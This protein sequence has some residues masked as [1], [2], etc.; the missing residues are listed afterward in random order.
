MNFIDLE[1]DKIGITCDDDLKFFVEESKCHKLYFD[2]NAAS[3]Q[4]LSRKRSRSQMTEEVEGSRKIRKLLKE[5]DL[6]SD[7]SAMDTDDESD[8]SPGASTSDSSKTSS[9]TDNAQEPVDE[10]QPSTSA[11]ASNQQTPKVNIISVDII[12]PS[13][14]QIND[15]A[16]IHISDDNGNAGQSAD[17][18]AKD[19]NDVPIFEIDENSQENNDNENDVQIVPDETQEKTSVAEENIQQS[20]QKQPTKK[21][22]ETNRII[23]SD[24]SDDE[25]Q[26][27]T[28]NSSRRFS[29]GPRGGTYS[30]AYSFCNDNGNTYG[31]RASYSGYNPYRQHRFR[32]CNS[33]RWNERTRGFQ[34]QIR[35]FHQS[36]A[37]NLERINQNARLAGQHA[38]RAVRAS[39]AAIPDLVSNFRAHFVHPLFRVTDINQQVFSSFHRR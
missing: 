28:F 24:S 30:S 5:I 37:E 14:T 8:L 1:N 4:E 11:A 3:E 17:S 34:E 2:F 13:D 22:P 39:T 23:I 7:S 35:A 29:D 10:M 26:N 20:S 9:G 27:H 6:S 32:R 36:N 16:S 31:T 21:K 12:K 19:G 38:A 25:E 18:A 33:D 15:Q